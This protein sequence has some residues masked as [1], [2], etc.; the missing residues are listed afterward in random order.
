MNSCQ[1]APLAPLD[2]IRGF[3]WHGRPLPQEKSVSPE[4]PDDSSPAEMG[5][6]PEHTDNVGHDQSE[7]T[8]AGPAAADQQPAATSWRANQEHR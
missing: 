8:P 6:R 2:F 5:K 4:G 3:L 1:Q 7:L